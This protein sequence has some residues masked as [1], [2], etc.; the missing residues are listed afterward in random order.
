RV[1][2]VAAWLASIEIGIGQVQA[3]A[4]DLIEHR[5]VAGAS[6][7]EALREEDFGFRRRRFE[8]KRLERTDL[9]QQLVEE[10]NQ[11]AEPTGLDVSGPEL[12]LVLLPGVGVD[13]GA[14]LHPRRQARDFFFLALPCRPCE[15]R[16][17][18]AD[19]V[20]IGRNGEVLVAEH[21]FHFETV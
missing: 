19:G 10:A 11:T 14:L 13:E 5:A 3:A 1:L 7:L 16:N 12:L 18:L 8:R 4:R 2:A 17:Q 15:M 20:P 9:R 21:I 6:V